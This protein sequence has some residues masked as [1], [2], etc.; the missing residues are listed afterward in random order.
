MN[1]D[2]DRAREAVQLLVDSPYFHLHLKKLRGAAERPRALPFKEPYE[3]FNELVA[4]GR[5]NVQA[6]ENL[7]A[8][9][10]FK[11]SGKNEYQRRFMAD[12]RRR[13][14]K[15]I[16]LEELMTRTELPAKAKPVVL[17][18]QR[19]VWNKERDA[20]IAATAT[21]PVAERNQLLKEFWDRKEAEL[22]ELIEE[23]KRAKDAKP[24]AR[25]R[26]VVVSTPEPKTHFGK[27]LANAIKK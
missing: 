25:K 19:A 10:E 14:R 23:A 13:E 27:A 6:M 20:I 15:V 8:V 22:D 11:R 4:I 12:K 5:Q 2:K 26:V 17:R 1:Y 7:I 24:V 16:E 18:Q 9:A 3:V 21:S